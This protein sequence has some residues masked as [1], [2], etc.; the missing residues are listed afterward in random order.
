M[1]D[2]V[3]VDAVRTPIGKGRATGTLAGVHPVDLHAHAIRA[4][5]DR[6]GIDPALIDDVISG[7]VGQIGEQKWQHRALGRARRRT[8]GVR[9]RG[10]H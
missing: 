4:L 5:V 6:T 10:H 2:A 3:I 9:P 7:A 8:A 1:K